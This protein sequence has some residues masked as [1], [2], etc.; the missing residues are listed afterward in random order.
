MNLEQFGIYSFEVYPFAIYG[1]KFKNVKVL[2]K[3]DAGTAQAL[4]LDIRAR[5]AQ[6]YS[7]LPPETPN[8]PTK[9]GYL[10]LQ[11]PSGEIEIIGLPWIIP[12]TVKTVTLGKFI[13]EIDNE[14]SSEQ[15]K[16]IQALV[17]NGK[18]VTKIE[19]QSSAP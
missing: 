4:G 16:I 9:Y 5:H 7:T 10:R 19:F 12:N 13:I 6:V 1:T 3:L 8:D 11:L 14:A 18:K 17:A 2:S 15:D